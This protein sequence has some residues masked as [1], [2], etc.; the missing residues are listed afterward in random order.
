[1]SRR[2]WLF[3]LAL[4]V[5][6]FLVYAPAWNGQPIWDDE[7]HLT[8]P[9]LRSL[10]GLARIWTEPAAAPQYYPVLHTVFWIEQKLWGDWLLPYHL[11]TV[12]LHVCTAF[13]LLKILERLEVP[14]AW[15]AAGIFAVHPVMVESVAWMC[16]LKNTLSGVLCAATVLVYL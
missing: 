2:D 1:M 6:T 12:A 5:V 10:H 16:E 11:V 7:T 13:L 4:L 8:P 9:Q 3:A 14:G 15:L